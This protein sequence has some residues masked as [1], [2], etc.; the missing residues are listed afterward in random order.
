MVIPKSVDS[1][2]LFLKK[3]AFRGADFSEVRRKDIWSI[4]INILREVI[5]N[6]LVHTD[7]SH[8]GSPIC[9]AFFDDRIEVENPGGLLPG[10]TVEDMKQ[11]VSQI[12][13]PVI[14][15]VLRE[16][17]LIEQWGSG[18]PSIFCEAKANGLAEP[19]ILE[20]GSLIRVVIYLR[21]ARKISSPIPGT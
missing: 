12:R 18:I 8:Q 9:I 13:N 21:N 19:K 10:L 1:I 2:M 17:A 7:Y 15:R 6:A 11:G 14:A 3:H 4:P 20:L 16:L 5:I